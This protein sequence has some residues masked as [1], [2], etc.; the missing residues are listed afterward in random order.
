MSCVVICGIWMTSHPISNHTFLDDN[1]IYVWKWFVVFR[2]SSHSPWQK[3]L[4]W[5]RQGCFVSDS[6]WPCSSGAVGW[7][8]ADLG[9]P[10]EH[11][12]HTVEERK[13]TNSFSQTVVW[14]KVK[15]M[16]VFG[17]DIS[18]SNTF[19]WKNKYIKINIS[20][21]WSK[22]HGLATGFICVPIK[23]SP[24]SLRTYSSLSSSNGMNTAS[25]E[26]PKKNT[27]LE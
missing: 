4:G 1:D 16:H 2:M 11:P 13:G 27:Y 18:L 7:S 20:P 6:P 26:R 22:D 23:S 10:P 5:G 14:I 15:T 3:Q 8:E 9:M 12:S 21:A 25:S 24:E 19:W 17:G